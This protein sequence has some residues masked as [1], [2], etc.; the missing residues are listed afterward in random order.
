MG[1]ERTLGALSTDGEEEGS[2]QDGR[3]WSPAGGRAPQR[4]CENWL[5]HGRDPGVWASA[6]GSCVPP[7]APSKREGA[8]AERRALSRAAV[9]RGL[10]RGLPRLPRAVRA[11]AH[12]EG[13][14][15]G[16]A[17]RKGDH[18]ASPGLALWGRPLLSLTWAGGWARPDPGG[19]AWI[20]TR[21]LALGGGG[22]PP[23]LLGPVEWARP[24]PRPDGRS[25]PRQPGSRSPREWKFW[26]SSTAS[27]RRV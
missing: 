11:V 10:A 15:V 22:L 17:G 13:S 2:S 20:V 26:T 12:A 27:S 14:C 6:R 1:A 18:G 9:S 25:A 7:S 8:C 21:A 23:P 19:P 4:S 16:A 24:G 3:Y 5:G